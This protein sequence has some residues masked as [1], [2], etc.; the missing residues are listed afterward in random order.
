MST[1]Q[2]N[3]QDKGPALKMRAVN[4][5]TGSENQ[6]Q[7]A[8]K[9][10]PEIVGSQ[11]DEAISQLENKVNTEDVKGLD[12][13]YV[14]RN[15]ITI[16]P[17]GTNSNYRKV[18]QK[19]LSDKIDYIGSSINSS[20]I[21]TSN[22]DEMET[23]MP[24]L[25]GIASNHPDFTH[26]V[27]S[28]FNNI[29]V[30]VE[31]VGKVFDISFRFNTKRDFLKYRDALI[32]IEEAYNLVNKSDIKAFKEALERK[33]QALNDLESVQHRYGTPMN[34]A[35]YLMYRHC[36]LYSD[37]AKDSSIVPFDKNARFFIKDTNKE[38]T[39][40][41]NHRNQVN[42]A[43]GYFVQCTLDKT[44]FD[45]VY[46]QYCVY[47]NR[48]VAYVSS[49]DITTREEELDR[50]SVEE[51][52]KFNEIFKDKDLDTKSTIEMLIA[53]GELI[54]PTHSQNITTTDGELVGRNIKEA[55]VWFKDIN[56]LARVEAYKSKL[57]Y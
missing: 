10:N 34:I 15:S 42:L 27:K 32:K 55:V 12:E 33:I 8:P 29:R 45:N 36:L 46:I 11:V 13:P 3:G 41:R 49:I 31:S 56:N 25:L 30:P 26:R 57:R 1:N 20:R 2:G 6:N 14:Y 48:P 17:I 9:Q 4:G 50:F 5:A 51:P 22:K 23:Y 39:K 28:Y 53:R 38:A 37:V 52:A 19:V 18:N 24:N 43:K 35:D 21:I 54:R 44:L 7:E 40:L 16:A 47:K